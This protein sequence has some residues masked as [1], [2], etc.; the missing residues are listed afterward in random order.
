MTA[1]GV[2]LEKVRSVLTA[3]VK[4]AGS[5]SQR[6]LARE[7]GLDRDAVYDLIQGRNR[8]PSLK[9]LAA[10]AEAIGKDLSV[11]GV[12]RRASVPSAEE[13]RD[14]LV[15]ILPE[16]PRRGSWERKASFVAEALAAA[17][18][19]PPTRKAR[20]RAADRKPAQRRATAAPLP[21]P[22]SRG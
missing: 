17:L 9:V 16:M 12:G 10:L 21:A 3:A 22:T 1:E 4:P 15:E 14:V 18:R 19:L 2:D 13:L 8:N 6:G 20:R 5:F 7:A 11:F